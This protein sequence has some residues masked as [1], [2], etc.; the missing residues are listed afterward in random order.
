M[1]ILWDFDGV[2]DAFYLTAD[3]WWSIWSLWAIVEFSG[4]AEFVFSFRYLLPQKDGL[5]SR[6]AQI[7]KR[8]RWMCQR[9]GYDYFSYF[10]WIFFIFLYIFHIIF[11][12]L[13]RIQKRFTLETKK[14]IISILF[15]LAKITFNSSLVYTSVPQLTWDWSAIQ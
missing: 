4:K 1:G 8:C 10:S 7:L 14:G 5:P 11:W 9:S 6:W 13:L 3:L 15:I 12:I 2:K